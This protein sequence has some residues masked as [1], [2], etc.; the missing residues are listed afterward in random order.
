LFSSLKCLHLDE[1]I[2][3]RLRGLAWCNNPESYAGGGVA[4]GR[5]TLAGQVKGEQQRGIHWSYRLGGGSMG[6]HPIA[7]GKNPH[8][9]KPR[10]RLGKTYGLSNKRHKARK[11]LMNYGTWNVQGI[12]GKME[13]ITSELGKLKL[14]IIIIIFINFNWVVTR[15]QWL[16]YMYTKYEIG[17]Y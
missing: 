7:R 5:A 9:K 15:W 12:R 17:Y 6:Q 8:A 1:S 4:T 11:R 14:D 10:Q 13:E 16:F 3:C 2:F